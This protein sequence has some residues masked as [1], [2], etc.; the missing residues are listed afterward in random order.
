MLTVSEL[1]NEIED[2]SDEVIHAIDLLKKNM[3]SKI[4][5][6]SKSVKKV[7]QSLKNQEK[8]QEVQDYRMNQ[9]MSMIEKIA[10]RDADVQS[11][12]FET[13]SNM[14]RVGATSS[15]M[16]SMLGRSFKMQLSAKGNNM[17]KRFTM[18]NKKT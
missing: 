2:E 5:N 7:K 8:W 16:Q 9:V 17:E 3:L 6:I 11:S 1:E 12:R 10:N 15:K 18:M 4:S 14:D 13:E